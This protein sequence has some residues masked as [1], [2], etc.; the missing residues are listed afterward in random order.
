VG[1]ISWGSSP[2]FLP[3]ASPALLA[4]CAIFFTRHYCVTACRHPPPYSR[5]GSA[6]SRCRFAGLAPQ[7]D[8]FLWRKE[9]GKTSLGKDRDLGAGSA[10]VDVSEVSS[11]F[12]QL[13]GGFFPDH[14]GGSE[15]SLSCLCFVSSSCKQM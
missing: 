14:G 13:L 3:L 8:I 2:G 12:S 15:E 1:L 4:R 5:L 9:G 10:A 7:C 6:N 11:V